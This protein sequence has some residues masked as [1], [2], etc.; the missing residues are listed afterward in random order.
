[1][2]ILITNDDG[3]YAQGLWALV[4][5]I[6]QL[7][8]VLVVAPDREQSAV[9]TSLTLHQPVRVKEA[10]APIEGI[11]AYAVEGTPGDSVVLALGLLAKDIDLVLCGI[12]NGSNLG[13]DVLLSGTVGAALQGYFYGLS[14][15]AISVAVTEEARYDVAA[16]VAGLV[17]K[18]FQEGLLPQRFLLNINI[19]DSPASEIQGIELTRVGQRSY[20]EDI[21]KGPDWKKGY[22]WITRETPQ[23][24][25]EVGTDIWAVRRGRISITPLHSDLTSHQSPYLKELCL[26][27]WQWLHN[28]T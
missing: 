15:I 27:L 1:L 16:K 23:G 12:N 28:L 7:G 14:A 22:Y 8:E 20:R 5:E 13:N 24:D 10:N 19:P 3:I 4:E 11:K 18:K 21:R 17:V 2:K 9:S 25:E 6:R 26:S